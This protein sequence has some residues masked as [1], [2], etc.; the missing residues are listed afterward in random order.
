LSDNNNLP[1]MRQ[2]RLPPRPPRPPPVLSAGSVSRFCPPEDHQHPAAASHL[3]QL[4]GIIDDADPTLVES[5]FARR[6][7]QREARSVKR[8][9]GLDND[10]AVTELASILDEDGYPAN[11]EKIRERKRA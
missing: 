5:A 11:W 8:L 3:D 7:E 1:Q 10:A 4:L 9:E 2:D 6:A